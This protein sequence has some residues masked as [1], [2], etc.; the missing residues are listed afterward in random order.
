[1]RRLDEARRLV[2]HALEKT[3]DEIAPGGALGT[4]SGWDSLG[5]MRIVMSLETELDRT[6]A[7]HEI[8][9]IKSLAD[10][11]AL[12]ASHIAIPG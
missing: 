10:I 2:A 9:E 5:H 7:A 8:I 3:V 11:A 6:L 1:M 4:Q 12:L